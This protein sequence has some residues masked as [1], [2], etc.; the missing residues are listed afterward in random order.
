MCQF[1]EDDHT[2]SCSTVSQQQ[3]ECCF[4]QES[5]WL[6]VM[7]VEMRVIVLFGSEVEPVCVVVVVSNWLQ[8]EVSRVLQ[9]LS[10]L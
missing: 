1:L 7:A 6:Q 8:E 4:D 10:G 2:V 3:V 5:C 9:V